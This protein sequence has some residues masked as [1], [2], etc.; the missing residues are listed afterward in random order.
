MTIWSCKR[1]KMSLE[2]LSAEVAA[3]APVYEP[4]GTHRTEGLVNFYALSGE[5][6]GQADAPE[7]DIGLIIFGSRYFVRDMEGDFREAKAT[8]ARQS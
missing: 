7:A 2:Q 4:V 3:S 1:G 8:T 5:M 6:I